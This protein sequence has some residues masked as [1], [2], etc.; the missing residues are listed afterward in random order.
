V[1]VI[2]VAPGSLDGT[3]LD[4]GVSEASASAWSG[5]A[6]GAANIMEPH[7]RKR[8]ENV[9]RGDHAD[10]GASPDA[11]AGPNQPKE[12]DDVIDEASDESF[13]A[14]DPPSFTPTKA[15][16]VR[17][18]PDLGTERETPHGDAPGGDRVERERD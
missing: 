17:S 11:K 14:S 6:H 9:P 8:R 7:D 10:P 12:P 1:H 16:T 4:D 15:G 2:D 3:R 18:N 5:A 13:P